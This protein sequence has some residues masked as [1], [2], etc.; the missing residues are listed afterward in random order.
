MEGDFAQALYTHYQPKVVALG[1]VIEE[2][3]VYPVKGCRGVRVPSAKLTASGLEH[4]RLFC[5]ID[6]D[7]EVVAA[8]EAISK[9]KLPALATISVAF[10]DDGGA[11]AIE[12][13]A[14]GMAAPCRVPLGAAAYESESEVT[15]ECSGRSTTAAD[16]GGWRLGAVAG[17]AHARASAWL[18]EHLNRVGGKRPTTYALVRGGTPLAMADYPPEFPLI[19]RSKDAR[20]EYHARFAGNARRFADFAPLLLANRSSARFVGTRCAGDGAEYP[21]RSFRANVIVDVAPAWT[22]EAWA[23]IA[24]GGVAL[25]KI[26]ECPRCTVPCRDEATGRYLFEGDALRLWKVLKAAFPRKYADPEWGS[27]AG[28]YF[29][30]Y[31]GN[32]GVEGVLHVG[33]EIAVARIERPRAVSA[34]R[35]CAVAVAAAIAALVARR[36]STSSPANVFAW[37]TGILMAA[38]VMY[39]G[40]FYRTA[41]TGGT[42][43]G[44]RRA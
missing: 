13:S 31:F 16:G 15:V 19:A 38:L 44:E 6:V 29:G 17:H 12:L 39:L 10:T 33:D 43:P 14:E 8:R 21:I 23:E 35:C 41:I 28:A 9:R 11:P 30:V 2:L 37:L 40:N 4:D 34:L 3:W 7:G 27:W 36:E 22:E 5:V 42:A 20:D 24:V 18:T 32:A 1:P 26:K 25:R